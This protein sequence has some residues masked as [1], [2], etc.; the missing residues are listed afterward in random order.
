MNI[1]FEVNLEKMGKSWMQNVYFC[2]T[3]KNKGEWG[4]SLRLAEGGTF[5]AGFRSWRTPKVGKEDWI[6]SQKHLGAQSF[7]AWAQHEAIELREGE[8]C[9]RWDGWEWG[10]WEVLTPCGRGSGRARRGKRGVSAR[11]I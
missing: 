4:W 6:L 8:S 2:R 3:G 7:R 5:E 11:L 10:S 1:W 9:S